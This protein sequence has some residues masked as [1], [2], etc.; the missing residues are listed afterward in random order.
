MSELNEKNKEELTEMDK[1]EIEALVKQVVNE[2][3]NHTDEMNQYKA[4]CDA[5]VAEANAA[6]DAAVAEKNDLMAS[7][8]QIKTALEQAKADLQKKSEEYEAAW[9]ELKELREELAK[10]EARERV[11]ELNAALQGFTDE[12]KA[13][14]Q[15]EIEAFEADPANSEINSVVNK[16]YEG[17]GRKALEDA[18][19]NQAAEENAAKERLEAQEDIFG[20]VPTVEEDVDIF[21]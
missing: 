17:L 18:A 20:D 13:Y 8:E 1:T 2:M 4:E 10:A 11:N 21:A 15:A 12:Q 9:E 5:K 16:V 7:S 14:A 6:L 19:A 3:S